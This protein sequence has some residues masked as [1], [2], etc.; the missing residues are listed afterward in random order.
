MLLDASQYFGIAK[1][2]VLSTIDG[3]ERIQLST[4]ILASDAWRVAEIKHGITLTSHQDPLVLG[5]QEPWSPKSVE[6]TLLWET[7][8][9][10]HYDVVRQVLIET[11]QPVAEPRPQARTP[12]DLTAGLNVRDRRV[13]VDR[14]GVCLLYTSP[15]PRD[16]RGSRMPSS[17]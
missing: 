5:W 1:S 4:T 16:Q 11:T 7:G 8:L 14:F 13:M 10:V 15:S 9:R 3:R 6:E 2:F 12:G 17:A